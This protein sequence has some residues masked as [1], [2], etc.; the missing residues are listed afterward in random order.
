MNP[1]MNSINQSSSTSPSGEISLIRNAKRSNDMRKLIYIL[2]CF[3]FV[4]GCSDVEPA[5]EVDY[6]MIR[7]KNEEL[8]EIRLKW[9]TNG[10]EDHGTMADVMLYLVEADDMSESI[11]G[12]SLNKISLSTIDFKGGQ[13]IVPS[14]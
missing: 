3:L 1:M 5:P 14:V 13:Y 6:F 8:T 2:T 4:A 7:E 11:P 9:K 10:I 12:T